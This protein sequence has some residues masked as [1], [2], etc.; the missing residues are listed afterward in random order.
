M[1]NV[2]FFRAADEQEP[3]FE[4]FP[5]I[6]ESVKIEFERSQIKGTGLS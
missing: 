3:I 2:P 1:I 4:L 6:I 5:C